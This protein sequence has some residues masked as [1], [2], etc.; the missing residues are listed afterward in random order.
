MH[1]KPRKGITRPGLPVHAARGWC[2]VDFVTLK[3]R[4]DRYV[5]SKILFTS[6]VQETY[7]GI[8]SK[9]EGN[10]IKGAEPAHNTISK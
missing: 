4:L 9:S 2:G 3:K 7:A 5:Y 8:F 10:Q 1:A 6:Q